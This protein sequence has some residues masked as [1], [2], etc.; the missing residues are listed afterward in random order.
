MKSNTKEIKEE[1]TLTA[2]AQLII[3]QYNEVLKGNC[4]IDGFLALVRHWLGFALMKTEKDRNLELLLGDIHV[5]AYE[6]DIKEA[7]DRID[8]LIQPLVKLLKTQ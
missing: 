6:Q 3:K 8:K 1:L 2:A 5:W 4:S 7:F